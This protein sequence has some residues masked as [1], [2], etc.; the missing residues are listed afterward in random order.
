ME[1]DLFVDEEEKNIEAG[2]ASLSPTSAMPETESGILSREKFL[3]N[4]RNRIDR[5]SDNVAEGMRERGLS[6]ALMK[7]AAQIGSFQGKVADT[8]SLDQFK[9]DMD[10]S[11]KLRLA[12]ETKGFDLGVKNLEG[13]K[14]ELAKD[15]R[16]RV[17]AGI[18]NKTANERSTERRE[19]K[20]AQLRDKQVEKAGQLRDKQVEKLGDV[21][22]PFQESLR[23]VKEVENQLGFDLSD[24]DKVTQTVKHEGK[25]KEFDLPGASIPLLGRITAFSGSARELSSAM[26]RVFNTE[27]K[28]RAGSTVTN[29]ELER[30]KNEF[31]SG[32]FNS[33]AEM[34]AALK[35]YKLAAIDALKNQEARFDPESV[36]QY[37]E[38]QGFT[39]SAIQKTPTR[40]DY[41]LNNGSG[42]RSAIAAPIK[43]GVKEM[44]V[45]EMMRELG[46]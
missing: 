19:D 2:A 15:R 42:E 16:A 29:T 13:A 26:A 9:K 1:D 21:A 6:N 11:N 33:E 4:Y 30:L 27:L 14:S 34:I 12:Q 44:S 8:S 5:S 36:A 25:N 46:E 17:L 37:S 31:G 10:E 41:L 40:G 32:R 43:K 39:S 38:N 3:D 7:G 28:T 24:Y 22:Q 18:R 35:D 23:A 20:A 45:E